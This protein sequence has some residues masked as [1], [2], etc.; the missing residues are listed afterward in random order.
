M[1]FL[2][3]NGGLGGPQRAQVARQVGQKEYRPCLLMR[4][5]GSRLHFD[6]D[7][8]QRAVRVDV[9]VHAGGRRPG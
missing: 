5:R 8:P 7:L 1:H 4:C 2:C 9:V 6:V 3:V